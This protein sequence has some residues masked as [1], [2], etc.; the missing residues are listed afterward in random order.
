MDNKNKKNVYRKSRAKPLNVGK[1]QNVRLRKQLDKLKR[2][3]SK[4]LEHN[5]IRNGA[6]DLLR[7]LSKIDENNTVLQ[8]SRKLSHLD[9]LIIWGSDESK[10]ITDIV[11]EDVSLE[12]E[13]NNYRKEIARFEKIYQVDC[14]I[15]FIKLYDLID[16]IQHFFTEKDYLGT[17][18]FGFDIC[19]GVYFNLFHKE[20]AADNALILDKHGHHDLNYYPY[21]NYGSDAVSYGLLYDY[22]LKGFFVS[23]CIADMLYTYDNI[24]TP[25]INNLKSDL[26][27]FKWHTV[28]DEDCKE[29]IEDTLLEPE[30]V[31]SYDDL[32]RNLQV[33]TVLHVVQSYLKKNPII[34]KPLDPIERYRYGSMWNEEEDIIR[35]KYDNHYLFEKTHPITPISN[36]HF[37]GDDVV[38]I[39]NRI[40][41]IYRI[42]NFHSDTH[43]GSSPR[44]IKEDIRAVKKAIRNNSGEEFQGIVES[45]TGLDTGDI[46]LK[47]K[48]ADKAVHEIYEFANLKLE[49]GSQGYGFVV[50]IYF[51]DKCGDGS[52]SKLAVKLLDQL[53]ED[54]CP[55]FIKKTARLHAK[56]RND[57]HIPR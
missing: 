36:D 41:I 42:V 11:K 2:Y 16:K 29:F 52:L 19:W 43:S 51:W 46:L 28:N 34:S 20:D 26:E 9:N 21:A 32:W 18:F 49:N 53:D 3:R 12:F 27:Y 45:I 7:A 40:E 8:I 23:A 56:V 4:L 48:I 33:V 55:E 6:E 47:Q 5:E 38:L 15:E 50:A 13:E 31:E 25:F 37:A 54:L 30:I 17:E 14:P 1:I 22:T 10:Y 35:K 39:S 44:W 24:F 57:M